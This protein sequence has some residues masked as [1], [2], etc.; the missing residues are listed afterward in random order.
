MSVKSGSF[1]TAKYGGVRGIQ[2][3][4]WLNGQS[5]AGNYSDIGYN[6][7]GSGSN[8]NSW[9]YV[10]N[11]Y[12]NV[13]GSRVFTQPDTK[14]QLFVGTVL[15]SGTLR[16]YHNSDGKKTFSADGGGTIYNYGTYQTG[17][18]SWELPR[19][20]R[21]SSVSGGT[22]NIGGTATINV[23]RA[24][25][26]F[27]HTL[28][29]SFGNLSGTIATGV[30]TSYKWTIP[31]SFYS[32]IASS[33]SGVGTITCETYSGG[34]KIGTS[35]CS[36][37]AKVVNSNPTFA[38]S[39]I[40][41]Q[42]TNATTTAIT[43]NSKHIVRNLSNLEITFTEAT[44]KNSASIV[45]YE[46]TFNGNT[47]T[48]TSAGTIDLGKVNLS[49]N[50]DLSIKAIDSRGNSTT[51]KV[52]VVIL[53]W[54][55]PSAIISAKRVNNYEDD[56]KLKVQV[57]ISSVN[58]KNSIQSIKYRYKKTTDTTFSQYYSLP[59]DTEES[60]VIDKLFA[61]DFQ[62]VIK[63]KFG[64]KTYNLIVAKGIP[65]M[66]IDVILKS[67]GI[68]CFPTKENSF[69]VEGYD[70]DNIHPIGEVLLSTKDANPST[71]TIGEWNLLSS[72]KFFSGVDTT[73]Y[74]WTRIS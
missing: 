39:Q 51:A 66:F 52:T 57:T 43:N 40:S 10:K 30:G 50:T 9:Y 61:W 35:T 24:D 47:K 46:L 60:I 70:F 53:D 48:L 62:V 71:Y 38:S 65:I 21:S 34:T 58:S 6:F 14:I 64:T 31:T 56:T 55:L 27:T 15:A 33:N 12:L 26:S 32:Q 13:N 3:N 74:L 37:T 45:K 54:V 28:K 4:W 23:S 72:G 68:N 17:S 7:V 59:N 11:G 20:A 16:I 1:E 5:I 69:E 29:Y 67:V 44:G 19:I 41:Y 42:D 2:F 49:S 18:G 73:F 36:F 22:G 8:A 63:D 25:N